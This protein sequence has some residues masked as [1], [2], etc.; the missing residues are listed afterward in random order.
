MVSARP[1]VCWTLRPLR[2]RPNLFSWLPGH[3]QRVAGGDHAHHA[4]QHAGAVRAA[5]DEVADEDGAYGP[6]GGGVD[7][8]PVAQVVAQLA[9][10][11]LQLGAAAVDVADDVERAGEVGQ[12][13]VALLG[14]DRGGLDLLDAAQD[15][16]LAEALALQ[17]AQ[18]AAQFAVWRWM[19]WRGRCPGRCGPRCARRTPLRARPARSRSAARRTPWPA[20]PAAG[21]RP[22]CTLV[23][24]TTVSRPGGE[25]LARDVVQH[26][27]GVRRSRSGRSRRR[28]PGRGRSPRR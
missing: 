11:R 1:W 24:S 27:E 8:R 15:V 10:Q 28:R 16:H 17:A 14:D 19:T 7:G 13:V 5:V 26:V 22:C 18:R 21:G 6:R 25:P 23:A 12:V 3:A 20:R 2:E 4:A 9:E